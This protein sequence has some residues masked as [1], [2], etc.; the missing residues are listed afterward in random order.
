MRTACFIWTVLLFAGCASMSDPGTIQRPTATQIGLDELPQLVTES[1]NQSSD[2]IY[3][4]KIQKWGY[5]PHHYFEIVFD[6]N[7]SKFYNPDGT[8][9]KRTHGGIL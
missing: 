1:I 2:T 6:N 3:I 5:F 8:Q 4:T 9:M 7:E